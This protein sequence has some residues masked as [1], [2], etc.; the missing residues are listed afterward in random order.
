V[1]KNDP[2][3]QA[4]EKLA[5][6]KAAPADAALLDQFRAFLR[7][8]SNLVIAK[9]AKIAGERRLADLLP[10]LVAAFLKLMADPARLDKRCAAVTEIVAAL[11]AMDYSEPEVYLNG[12]RHIQM[13]GSF[14]PPID[15][16]AQLR[17]LSAQGLVR[18]R[19]PDALAMA[20]TLLVD[21]EPPARIGAVRALASN[22]GD[23]GSLALRL[24][25][26]TGDRVPDV[27]A[28]CFSGLLASPSESTV[29]FVADYLDDDDPAIA[30]AA[31][32]ALGADR[33]T[34]AI[35]ALKDKWQRT[36]RGPLKK[37]L[38][39]ALATSR[40][41]DALQFLLSLLETAPSSD[42]AEILAALAAQR[43]TQ[44]IREAIH[45]ALTRRNDPILLAAFRNAFP[46]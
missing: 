37:A 36:R 41:E 44:S 5:L 15:S 43:P 35:V 29:A 46:A 26:L 28:E 6:L 40:S 32:L 24:K 22:G 1:A 17:G 8:R 2:I 21:P 10:D 38:L 30:E 7:N 42:A 3:E 9:A 27:L 39:L 25:V 33:S 23:A 19:Y 14:G 16:A 31:I 13:E 18:T 12:I 45:A 4:L 34:K 20:V 11:Y